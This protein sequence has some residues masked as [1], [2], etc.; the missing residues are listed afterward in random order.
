MAL[1]VY[2]ALNGDNKY[3]GSNDIVFNGTWSSSTVYIPPMDA[4]NYGA[5]QYIVLIQNSGSAPLGSKS[6]SELVLLRPD[7]TPP[8]PDP[9]PIAEAALELAET[10]YTL[11]CIGTNVG[12]NALTLAQQALSQ[13]AA[14]AYNLACIGTNVGTNALNAA[15]AAQFTAN[16]AKS[17][18][19]S[20]YTVAVAGTNLAQAAYNL[21]VIGT[22]TSAAGAYNL[23]AIGTNVGTN[24]LNAAA[25]AQTTA[26]NAI[27]GINGV[28]V[29]AVAGTNIALEALQIASI[30]TNV[31]TNALNAATQAEADAQSALSGV[32]SFGLIAQ[33]GTNLA[34]EALAIASAGTISAAS[35]Q[36]T[37][38]SAKSGVDSVYVV[39][40][41]GT[42]LATE[43]LNIAI[44]GTNLAR[45]AF[46]LAAIG[47]NVGSNAITLANTAISTANGATVL[48]TAGTAL[49]QSAYSL[50]A[51]GT[52]VGS[53]AY[54]L[55]QGIA[56]GVSAGAAYALASIGTNVGTNA[57]N[58]AISGSNLAWYGSNEYQVIISSGTDPNA[59]GLQPYDI[60]KG[61]LFITEPSVNN[62][63]DYKWS[64]ANRTWVPYRIK[65]TSNFTFFVRTDGNDSNTGLLNTAAG[66]WA[67]IQHAVDYIAQNLIIPTAF[68][69]TVQLAD[70]TYAENVRFPSINGGG[71]VNINGNSSTP[72]N[73]SIAPVSGDAITAAKPS[74]GWT[75]QNLKL[76]AANGNS[77][78]TSFGGV[79]VVGPNIV[80]AAAKSGG[81]HM[82]ANNNSAILLSAAAY[83][84]T[85]GTG[86]HYYA[87][88]G[89]VINS[90]VSP[91]VTITGSPTFTAFAAADDAGTVAVF[92]ATF[93]GSVTGKRFDVNLNGVIHTLSGASATYF[94]GTV[95][96]TTANG[97][98]YQ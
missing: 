60:N 64:T 40:V 8:G 44:A 56:S 34:L 78:A 84:I 13:S 51:I 41:A 21:A 66:A 86:N 88:R 33:A 79:V 67:T 83:T 59:L 31:G 82:I 96:G 11:A 55:A 72:S 90:S 57:L 63:N 12:T 16:S 39:S 25:A 9:L 65:L 35:A 3:L 4:V 10:A 36:F 29:I 42:N 37:A 17:G 94:P 47:T 1:Y 89:S 7:V 28:T 62:I 58:I 54:A 87:T 91:A 32:R 76:S 48:A 5:S 6:W 43:A 24:A 46:N 97:G 75:I 69:V 26:N 45:S 61:A 77:I 18:V 49:A 68:T 14:T 27:G 38:N 22:N 73:V 30:G 98:Q 53:N 15:A 93:S 70:G 50:A 52:N 20:V 23:A 71:S 2:A 80:F 74:S 19:D 85:G 92:G 95:S 81:F